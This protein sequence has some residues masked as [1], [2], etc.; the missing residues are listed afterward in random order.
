MLMR[1]FSMVIDAKEGRLVPEERINV[2]K[3]SDMKGMYDDTEAGLRLKTEDPII[4]SF[5]ERALPEERG[6]L[7]VAITS[8]RPG[9]IGEEYF[10][11]RGHYH[12]R[13]DTSEIYLGLK[14]EGWLLMQTMEGDFDSI[15]IRPGVAAYIPPFWGHRMVNT[16]KIPFVFFAVYSGEAGHNYGD[17]EKTGFVKILVERDGKPLLLDNPRWGRRKTDGETR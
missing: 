4:Y 2:R 16:G 6:H 7:Q 5:S 13:L 11:T 10:M 1:P 15:T 8:I 17:I 9:R 3:L 14:G 12:G